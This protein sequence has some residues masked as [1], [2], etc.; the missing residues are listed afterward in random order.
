[1][2]EALAFGIRHLRKCSMEEAEALV[3]R[4]MPLP[5]TA[6]LSSTAAA[7]QDRETG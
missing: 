1:L 5:P 3:N 7:G 6:P 2:P 4:L